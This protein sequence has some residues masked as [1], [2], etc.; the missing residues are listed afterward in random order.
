MSLLKS[1][2][3]CCL[4]LLR[5]LLSFSQTITGKVYRDSTGTPIPAATV[6][7]GGTMQ[8][9]ITNNNGEFELPAKQQQVPI[10]ASCVGYYSSTVK[11]EPGKPLKIYLKPKITLLQTVTIRADGME[12][13]QEEK[14][15]IREFLGSS[16]FAKSCTITNMDDITLFYSEKNKLLTA[17]CDKPIIIENRALGY[18]ISYYLDRFE[19]SDSRVLYTG[20][21]IFKELSPDPDAAT[22]R[23]REVAYKGSR[24]QF[25]RNLWNHTLGRSGFSIYNRY[26]FPLKEDHI[27]TTDSLQQKYIHWQ[28]GRIYVTHGKT[29][30]VSTLEDRAFINKDGFY[31]A[32]LQ[33]SGPMANQRIGDLLPFEYISATDV[34][35]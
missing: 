15:F 10:V 30:T 6:Y 34:K 27:L 17:S 12:R 7:Y 23:N 24:M 9:T 31:S 4:L 2:T 20:N 35:P 3:L 33:W 28:N 21:Y 1:C 8:G 13:Q 25:I 14:M 18:S 22:L 5:G 19:N 11:Y 29:S 26:N 32:G 16:A